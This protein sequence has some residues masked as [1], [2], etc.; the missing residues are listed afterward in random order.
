MLNTKLSQASETQLWKIKPV[1]LLLCGLWHICLWDVSSFM[2][3]CHVR[4]LLS[5]LPCIHR[6][7]G[8]TVTIWRSISCVY[9]RR[10]I[11]S[12]QRKNLQGLNRK[13]LRCYLPSDLGFFEWKSCLVSPSCSCLALRKERRVAWPPGREPSQT[14]EV[15]M[16]RGGFRECR[17]IPPPLPLHSAPHLKALVMHSSSPAT[18]RGNSISST[19][20]PC[21]I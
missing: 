3:V 16:G 4:L 1:V 5:G 8:F 21:E 19:V 20:R 14:Q 6:G 18:S 9:G 15:S 7:G 12:E 11:L 17:Q 2:L 10:R 13:G